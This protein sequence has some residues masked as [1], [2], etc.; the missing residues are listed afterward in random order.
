MKPCAC[1][2]S[3]S[4]FALTARLLITASQTEMEFDSEGLA[5]T[6]NQTGANCESDWGWV[7]LKLGAGRVSDFRWM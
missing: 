7:R 4:R 2:R 3:S 6:S 1:A 5:V